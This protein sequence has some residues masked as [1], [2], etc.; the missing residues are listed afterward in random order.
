MHQGDNYYNQIELQFAQQFDDFKH[1]STVVG[2][3]GGAA[4]NDVGISVNECNSERVSSSICMQRMRKPGGRN[5]MYKAF[6]SGNTAHLN[7]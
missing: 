7:S 5:S 6:V 4:C 3:T 1:M 2:L